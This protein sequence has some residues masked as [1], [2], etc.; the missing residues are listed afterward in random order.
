[1]PG[2]GRRGEPGNRSTLQIWRLPAP[3]TRSTLQIWN[4]MGRYGG[5]YYLRRP[6]YRR[7]IAVLA[8]HQD[9]R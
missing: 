5:Q 2:R 3:R 4:G 6:S 7:P 9:P 1:M 8:P